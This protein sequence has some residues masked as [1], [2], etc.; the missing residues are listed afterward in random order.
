MDLL[1]IIQDRINAKLTTTRSSADHST[2]DVR[3]DT[4]DA[5]EIKSTD[6][7]TE[8][9]SCTTGNDAYDA[10][11]ETV[12]T[13]ARNSP[14]P[15]IKNGY[16]MTEGNQSANHWTWGTNKAPVAVIQPTVPHGS[17]A[18]LTQALPRSSVKTEW[19]PEDQL[20]IDW[21]MTL[22][23][24]KEPFQ[25][26]PHIKVLNPEKFFAALRMDI[27]AGPRGPRGRHGALMDDLT[28]LKR[29]SH[30]KGEVSCAA[31]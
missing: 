6:T 23:P 14:S 12:L 30:Q 22:E 7:M 9:T 19:S 5:S 29:L 26:A 16:V 3:A 4:H 10:F 24:P 21:F 28:V 25:L 13:A 18:A 11:S 20:L 27:G 17:P 2:G 15:S 8:S 31:Q 1:A